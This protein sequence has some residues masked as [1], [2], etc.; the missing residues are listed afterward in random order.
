MTADHASAAAPSSEDHEPEGQQ[1]RAR[2]LGRRLRSGGR[3]DRRR[4]RSPA[5]GVRAT[6]SRG[7]P[8]A[9][10][11]TPQP[12]RRPLG[13]PLAAGGPAGAVGGGGRHVG[14][15]YSR[16]LARDGLVRRAASRSARSRVTSSGRLAAGRLAEHLAQ[17]PEDRGVPAVAR[18]GL[19]GADDEAGVLDRAGGQQGAP[20]LDLAVARQPGR[21]ARR[22]PRR[23]RRPAAAPARGSAGRS[24]S[25]GRPA[26][27]RRRR[28][29]ARSRR[30]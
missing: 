21:R 3:L 6:G 1:R 15:G 24:R 8:S 22:G 26:I 18:L 7:A 9:R 25:S 23:P 29:R 4:A 20:V 13:S 2:A 17:R 27:P 5:A 19:A 28:R 11:P 14:R 16:R 12:R 10:P 30:R